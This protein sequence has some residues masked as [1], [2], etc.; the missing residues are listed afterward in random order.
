[1]GEEEGKDPREEMHAAGRE[2]QRQRNKTQDAPPKVDMN[3]ILSTISL[4]FNLVY[5]QSHTDSIVSPG[6]FWLYTETEA[7]F[8]RS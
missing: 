8:P 7:L 1:M 5:C 2:M 6:S 4:T 3:I